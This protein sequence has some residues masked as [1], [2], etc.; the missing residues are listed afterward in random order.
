MQEKSLCPVCKTNNVIEEKFDFEGKEMS[1]Y[2]CLKCGY[3]SNSGYKVGEDIL[4]K[5]LYN[6]SQHS[7]LIMDIS[8]FDENTS[9]YWFPIVLLKTQGAVFPEG[10]KEEWNWVFIPIL[11][12]TEEEKPEYGDEFTT[13]FATDKKE[14]FDKF[15]FLSACKKLG[16]LGENIT[17]D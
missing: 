10:T 7:Q 5:M 3:H 12:I 4:N 6:N 1:S 8:Y 11:P 15:D 17:V 13:R 9:L 14:T 2:L 16:M